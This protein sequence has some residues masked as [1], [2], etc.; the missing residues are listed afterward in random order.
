MVDFNLPIVAGANHKLV[1]Y[2]RDLGENLLIVQARIPN[3]TQF[4]P[5]KKGTAH[6]EG[7]LDFAF[8]TE[9]VV[10][11][12]REPIGIGRG[13]LIQVHNR[14]GNG[15]VASRH[16]FLAVETRG[17]ALDHMAHPFQ[18]FRIWLFK[19]HR[20]NGNDQLRWRLRRDCLL[21][22]TIQAFAQ[23]AMGEPVIRQEAIGSFGGGPNHLIA[24]TSAACD[25]SHD[26]RFS[27]DH[28]LNDELGR[29]TQSRVRQQRGHRLYKLLETR[30]AIPNMI[31]L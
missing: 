19:I 14:G 31:A 4:F 21:G 27:R 26:R 8:L 23:G 2:P 12:I 10:R 20:F 13:G 16:A 24:M 1:V 18:L 11:D 29:R 28:A 9:K 22:E 5:R 25:P 17:C 3:E 30:T 7:A 6:A 15:R